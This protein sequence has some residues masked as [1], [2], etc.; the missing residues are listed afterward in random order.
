VQSVEQQ[1]ENPASR[2]FRRNKS[3]KFAFGDRRNM[4]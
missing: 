2:K 1:E 3:K 4:N